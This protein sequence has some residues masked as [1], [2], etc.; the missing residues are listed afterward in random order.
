M[1]LAVDAGNTEIKAGLFEGEKLAAVCRL[2]ADARLPG[3]ELAVRLSSLFTLKGFSLQAADGAVFSSVVPGLRLPL[4]Q[5]LQ[6]L[7]GSEPLEAGPGVK[8]GLNIRVDNPLSMGADFVCCA[9]GALSRF[10]P[11]MAVF[12]LGTATT[13]MVLDEKGTFVGKSILC[14]VS[15]GL[16][17]LSE[18]TAALPAAEL[19]AP[20]GLLGR[21]TADALTCGAVYGAAA[22]VDGLLAR[23]EAKYGPGLT[24]ILTGGHCGLIAPFCSWEVRT[25]LFLTLHGLR[26]IFL[27]NRRPL[28]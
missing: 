26:Q 25:D 9:V 13:V 22:M 12:D 18:H 17:A 21:N 7:S 2:A 23:F 6:M 20:G 24:G 15:L 27:K 16:T 28:Q 3:E 11:P 5:A 4:R 10:T 14:G 1:L 8:T 19:R